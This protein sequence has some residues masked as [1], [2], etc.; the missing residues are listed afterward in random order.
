MASVARARIAA[1]LERPSSSTGRI[2]PQHRPETALGRPRAHH[3]ARPPRRLVVAAA[4]AP[5]DRSPSASASPSP[6]TSAM[7][8]DLLDLPSQVA[9]LVSR[10]LEPLPPGFPPGPSG[11]SAVA[12]G[13]DPLAFIVEA[14]RTHGDVVGLKLAGEYVVL[15][16]DP[17][18]RATSWWTDPR[19][20]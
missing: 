20:S 10:S 15:V 18:W 17:R 8:R 4:G 5:P 9:R 7:V 11:D 16:G 12:L 6:P 1:S 2:A 13:A 14:S 3:R 19:C